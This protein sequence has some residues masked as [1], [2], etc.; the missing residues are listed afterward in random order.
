MDN[1]LSKEDFLDKKRD[2]SPLLVHLT[3]SD[4]VFFGKEIFENILNQ[5][6]LSAYKHN[7]FFSPAINQQE[8]S[9]Q[10][11]FKVV[12]FTETPIDQIH[13]LFYEGSWKQIKFEPYGLVFTKEFIRSKGGNPALY[14]SRDIAY[15]LWNFYY[16]NCTDELCR[17]LALINRYDENFDFHYEREWRI[18]G[19]L[20][21]ELTDVYCGLCPNADIPQFEEKF[22]P[23]KFIDPSWGINRIL[24]KLVGKIAPKVQ[25][26]EVDY[27]DIPF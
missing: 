10:N 11:K 14:M 7:C 18:V 20:F 6:S 5:K 8:S 16:N 4:E 17:L 25:V 13:M 15:P 19:N 27:P 1:G 24:D 3:K 22:P 2:Y 26:K 21:F 23:I 12:C 9:F